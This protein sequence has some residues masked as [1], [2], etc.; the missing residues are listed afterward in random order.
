MSVD[1][2]YLGYPTR[3]S[4]ALVA[5]SS[6]VSV[7]TDQMT[8][9]GPAPGVIH[10]RL[11]VSHFSFDMLQLVSSGPDDEGTVGIGLDNVTIT[12]VPEATSLL[13]LGFGGLALLRKRS[14]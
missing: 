7:A 10:H 11:S 4:L 12:L 3:N 2:F 5:L 8:F 13:L 14:R 6:G 9:S 1:V